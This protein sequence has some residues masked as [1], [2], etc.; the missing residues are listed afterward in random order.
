MKTLY[1]TNSKFGSIEFNRADELT[2]LD[3]LQSLAA[4]ITPGIVVSFDSDNVMGNEWKPYIKTESEYLILAG[5][6]VIVDADGNLVPVEWPDTS[7]TPDQIG[8]GLKYVYLKHNPS[9]FEKGTVS[10][11]DGDTH[12]IGNGTE[13]TKIFGANRRIIV[14][15]Q[16][17]AISGVIDDEE[18]VL[19]EAFDEVTPIA[20][21]QFKVGAWFLGTPPVSL[22]DNLLYQYNEAQII[23]SNTAKTD[24]GWYFLG[25][26]TTALS[27]TE[28]LEFTGSTDMRHKS[29]FRFQKPNGTMAKVRF[30][31]LTGSATEIEV[32]PGQTIGF[33]DSYTADFNTVMVTFPGAGTSKAIGIKYTGKTNNKL[34]GVTWDSSYPLSPAP[35][36]IADSGFVFTAT[37]LVTDSAIK[38]GQADLKYTR[39][40]STA[41]NALTGQGANA[42]YLTV[43]ENLQVDAEQ[44]VLGK[45]SLYHMLRL[46][47]IRNNYD[48]FEIDYGNGTTPGDFTIKRNGGT[49]FKINGT[50]GV[51]TFYGN[52]SAD[53]QTLD[54]SNVKA[55]KVDLKGLQT[56][57]ATV[58]E[59]GN[60]GEIRFATDGIYFCVA[61]NTWKKATLSSF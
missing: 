12:V 47:G 13:F 4:I 31:T 1:W 29:L 50:T 61:S 25:T 23:F 28:A 8:S 10:F 41:A 60:V 34:T 11:T 17:F 7:Y 48:Y 59:P 37:T 22:N 18:L 26:V 40:L 38:I 16:V 24:Q 42:S 30:N 20:D 44:V 6:A 2:K 56:A 43:K 39:A 21:A 46:Q 54:C 51:V 27:P 14:G 5:K 49:L 3:A 33:P 55:A 35:T 52:L 58:N 53:G 32:Y 36:I 57:P 19:T 45:S 9:S 15:S